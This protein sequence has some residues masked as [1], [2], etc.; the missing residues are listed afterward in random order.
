[1]KTVHVKEAPEAPDDPIIAE[2]HEIRRRIMEE[3]NH[4]PKKFRAMLKQTEMQ[5]A[6]RLTTLDLKPRKKRTGRSRQHQ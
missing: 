6:D 1:M 4:D 5:Y 2:I 3:C